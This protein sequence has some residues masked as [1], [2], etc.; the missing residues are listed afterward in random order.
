MLLCSWAGC[1]GFVVA[2]FFGCRLLIV[3]VGCF[4]S[5][6]GCRFMV[7]L[8]WLVFWILFV[9]WVIFRVL[10]ILYWL[11]VLISCLCFCWFVWFA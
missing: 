11:T 9:W 2:A 1:E 8:F 10:L 7:C 4:M 6:L 5:L 3:L